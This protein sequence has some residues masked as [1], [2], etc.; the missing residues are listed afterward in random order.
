MISLCE[1]CGR[2]AGATFCDA[3]IDAAPEEM[4]ERFRERLRDLPDFRSAAARRG[5]ALCRAALRG[6]AP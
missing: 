3:C 2:V 4:A 1:E 6:D 5:V